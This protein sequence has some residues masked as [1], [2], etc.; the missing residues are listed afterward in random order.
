[1]SFF[2]GKASLSVR[3]KMKEFD[4]KQLLKVQHQHLDQTHIHIALFNEQH[5]TS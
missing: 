3:E 5:I 2:L 4:N 1:M